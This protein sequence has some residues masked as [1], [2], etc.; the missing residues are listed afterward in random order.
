MGIRFVEEVDEEAFDGEWLERRREREMEREPLLGM[1]RRERD[2]R[3]S[4]MT[5]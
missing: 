1:G 4:M 3:G 2:R 5:V